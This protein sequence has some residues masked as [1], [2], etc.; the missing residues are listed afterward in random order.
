MALPGSEPGASMPTKQRI[1]PVF[2]NLTCASFINGS[3]NQQ[4]VSTYFQSTWF[5]I[6]GIGA[7]EQS[8][9]QSQMFRSENGDKRIQPQTHVSECF[10]EDMHGGLCDCLSDGASNDCP[11]IRTGT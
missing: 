7:F 11:M 6:G 10:L 3:E 5:E 9:V 4:K 8:L 2:I 1:A